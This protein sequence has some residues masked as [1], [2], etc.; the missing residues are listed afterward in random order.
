VVVVDVVLLLPNNPPP[1]PVFVAGAA[2]CAAVWPNPPKPVEPV[3]G[4]VVLPNNPPAGFGAV[5]PN[6][7]PVLGCWVVFDPNRP[8]VV[9]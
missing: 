8:P 3:A 4:V 9:F 2:G 6:N 1:R 5:L 7:P